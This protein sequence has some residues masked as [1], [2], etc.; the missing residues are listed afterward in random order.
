MMPQT[1]IK[2]LLRHQRRVMSMNSSNDKTSFD[3]PTLGKS[4]IYF[5]VDVPNLL[6]TIQN[7]TFT[8]K[9]VRVFALIFGFSFDK[10][11]SQ[12]R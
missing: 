5:I 10:L 11:I 6:K 12:S 1:F 7:N 3:H 8:V 9:D 2:M 4:F